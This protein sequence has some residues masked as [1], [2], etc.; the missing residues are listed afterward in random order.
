[1]NDARLLITEIKSEISES[2]GIRNL[3]E[4]KLDNDEPEKKDVE[5]LAV[6]L[7]GEDTKLD[8]NNNLGKLNIY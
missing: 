5:P 1:M 3:E 4:D 7:E 2:V 6:P 8:E